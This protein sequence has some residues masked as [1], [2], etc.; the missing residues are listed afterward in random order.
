MANSPHLLPALEIDDAILALSGK[1]ASLGVPT[2]I[3]SEADL[4]HLGKA[5]DEALTALKLY[6]FY[7]LDVPSH[8]AE[9]KTALSKTKSFPAYKGESD[10]SSKS[11]AQLA[12][13]LKTQ[14]GAIDGLGKFAK[15]KGV[16][17]DLETA[18]AFVG[19]AFATGGEIDAERLS[20]AWGEVLDVV[21][22]DLYKE[23]NA[24]GAAMRENVVSRVKYERLEANGPRMGEI[25]A[26]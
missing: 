11:T 9:L 14:D 2:L 26:K 13:L 15:R 19:A 3:N 20:Q 18:L 4:A 7:A 17:V 5:V 25:S 6:E 24:D 23:F 22:V 16:H 10:L 8:V 1:L 21:N 12:D